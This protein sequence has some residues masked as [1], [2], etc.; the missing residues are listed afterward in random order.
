MKNHAAKKQKY[1][2]THNLLVSRSKDSKSISKMEV[3]FYYSIVETL[4]K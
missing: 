1:A 4:V 2:N 3:G